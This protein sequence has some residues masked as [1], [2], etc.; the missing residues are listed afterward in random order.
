MEKSGETTSRGEFRITVSVYNKS[1]PSVE[2]IRKSKT[3][4]IDT[5]GLTD[6]WTTPKKDYQ[7]TFK[8]IDAPDEPVI[9]FPL[10]LEP[11]AKEASKEKLFVE[12]S[13][14]AARSDDKNGTSTLRQL[15]DSNGGAI[16]VKGL[17][18]KTA[19]DFSELLDHL[20]G[21]GEHAWYPHEHVGMEV[22]RR[23]QAKNVLTA[24]E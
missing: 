5:M 15:L 8:V 11:A 23:P 17:P 14:V 10:I 20:A 13:K 21:N 24:N 6:Y 4:S 18:L 9:D 2:P 19:E 1:T 12:L 7:K 22:L 3:S 16:H